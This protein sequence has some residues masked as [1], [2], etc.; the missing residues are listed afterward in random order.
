MICGSI[1]K[2]DPQMNADGRR[3][4]RGNVGAGFKPARQMNLD[5][6]RK[7]MDFCKVER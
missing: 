3:W 7:A 4:Y 6:R 1:G 5:G 2:C